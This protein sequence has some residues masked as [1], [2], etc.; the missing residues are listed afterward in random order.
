MGS[1][2]HKIFGKKS[3]TSK[4]KGKFYENMEFSTKKCTPAQKFLAKITGKACSVDNLSHSIDKRNNLDV[5]VALRH[6]MS[7]GEISQ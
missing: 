5:D 7:T 6:S 4:E 1:I 3:G 2:K